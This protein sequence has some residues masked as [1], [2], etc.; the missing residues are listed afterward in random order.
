MQN[1]I[2][3]IHDHLLSN[4]AYAQYHQDVDSLV[5]RTGPGV[6][7]IKTVHDVEYKPR[8]DK[9][10]AVLD[11]VRKSMLTAKIEE[12][13]SARDSLYRYFVLTMAAAHQHFDAAKRE[14]ARE[15]QVI[16]DNYG[17]I[18]AKS[19]D[20]ES[21]AMDD[22]LREL[23]VPENVTRVAALGL[24]DCV[25]LLA[26]ANAAFIAL[27]RERYGETSRQLPTRMKEARA[28]LNVA[29]RAMINRLEA[30]VTLNGIDS[31]PELA[32]FIAELNAI[33]NRYK[34]VLAAEKGRRASN[35]GNEENG[36]EGNEGDE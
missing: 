19:Y 26:T 12:Q 11:T 21:A 27:M 28:D 30:I 24:A 36:N 16:V 15:L 1:V 7:G 17:N 5:T 32:P 8:L 18:S 14:A 35:E 34:N 6:V 13:D 3:R 29:F 23:A 9:V 2:A 10:L 4:D 22:F 33:T 20:K 25:A 31:I